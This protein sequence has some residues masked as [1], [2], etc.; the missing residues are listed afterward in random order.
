[1]SLSK[2]WG[3]GKVIV[4]KAGRGKGFGNYAFEREVLP[5]ALISAY[6]SPCDNEGRW[7]FLSADL[8]DLLSTGDRYT[9]EP[10]ETVS[11]RMSESFERSG[12]GRFDYAAM[13]RQAR[14]VMRSN[15]C[16]FGQIGA[17]SH[18]GKWE[19]LHDHKNGCGHAV[20]TFDGPHYVSKFYKDPAKTTAVAISF[21]I[22]Q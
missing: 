20:S 12:S 22:Y 13:A 6:E 10:A 5:K 18:C 1:M 2:H 15:F 17:Y 3:P 7:S 14:V 16:P 21:L 19:C 4:E 9:S 8:Y 11:R